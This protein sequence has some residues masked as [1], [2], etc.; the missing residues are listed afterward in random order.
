MPARLSA[1][2]VPAVS[3]PL[4]IMLYKTIFLAYLAGVTA[5]QAC[6]G[7]LGSVGTVGVS[8]VTAFEAYFDKKKLRGVKKVT[9]EDAAG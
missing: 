6:W 7:L 1:L 5:F 8:A 9:N 3:S 4:S 2:P